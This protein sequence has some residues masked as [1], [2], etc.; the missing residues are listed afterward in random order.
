MN[1]ITPSVTIIDM[2]D[3]SQML[4][5]IERI[6]RVCYKSE[7]N[8]TE[9]SAEQFV[10]NII[11]NGH[12]SVI[13]HETVTVKVIC[14]RGVTHEIVRHRLASYSQESTR[15]CNYSN[16]TFSNRITV[17]DIASGFKYDLNNETDAKKYAIWNDA[18]KSAEKYYFELLKLGAAPQ[19]ARSVL[20]NSLKTEII[21]TM[22]LR[23]WRHFFILRLDKKAHPQMREVAGL[24]YK[25]FCKAM[26]VFFNSLDVDYED[27]PT[28]TQ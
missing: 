18:M 16:D 21:I 25:E 17:I 6:G 27:E 15:Y 24:V 10:R 7:R 26:P 9:T 14:D 20:P 4:K 5:K 12:E 8:I 13:E 3:Y 22:N 2:K 28:E 11:K 19:E 1:I 23:E